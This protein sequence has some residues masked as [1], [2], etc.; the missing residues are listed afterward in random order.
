MNIAL[1]VLD[2]LR[3]DAFDKYFDWV[4]G[5][6]FENAW[7]TSHWTVPAHASLFAGRYGSELGV[8]GKNKHLNCQE[9]TIAE[10]LTDAGWNTRAFSCNT[11]VSHWFGFDRGF[12][13]FKGTELGDN[14]GFNWAE[15]VFDHRHEGPERYFKLLQKIARSDAPT[16]STLKQGAQI[17][18]KDL[19]LIGSTETDSGAQEVLQ[20][21]ESTSWNEGEFLFLNLMEAHAPYETPEKYQTVEPVTIDGPKAT[22]TGDPGIDP[23]HLRNAYEDCVRYLS[24]IYTDI[25]KSLESDF[26][27]IITLSDH[28]EAFG[29]YDGWEHFSGL[30]PEVTHVPLIISTPGDH[31]RSPEVTERPVSL[32]DVFQTI[33][34]YTGVDPPVEARGESLFSPSSRHHLIETHGMLAK[35]RDRLEHQGFDAETLDAFDIPLHAIA[36]SSYSFENFDEEIVD[37]NDGVDDAESLITELVDELD[38]REVGNPAGVPEHIEEQLKHLGYA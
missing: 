34:N 33:C 10:L 18:L 29:E 37:W 38:V 9:Q 4:P 26:D 2:T 17:K 32:L 27:V 24:D 14:V 21:V 22:I 36:G 28:G 20:F 25:Y 1:V 11:H 8:H 15:F 5:K 16:F 19:G 6:R 30:W 7:S 31:V 23:D 3:K 35:T 12:N 13:Q